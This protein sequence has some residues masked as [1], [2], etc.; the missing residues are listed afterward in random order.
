MRCPL[1]SAQ[2]EVCEHEKGEA[3]TIGKV[4]GLIS[5]VCGFIAAFVEEDF[6][7]NPL[8][9]FVLAI[10]FVFVLDGIVLPFGR[11]EP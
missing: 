8:A 4:L 3:M 1:W 10:A 2:H 7:F 5:I 9:W 6:L 11:R